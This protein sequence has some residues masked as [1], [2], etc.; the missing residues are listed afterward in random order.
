MDYVNE[1]IKYVYQKYNTFCLRN[2]L[3]SMSGIEFQK[4]MKKQFDLTIKNVEHEGRKV[5]VYCNE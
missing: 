2:N 1:P 5:R 3:Q 4:L